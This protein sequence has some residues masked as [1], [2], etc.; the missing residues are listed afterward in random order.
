MSFLLSAS[1]AAYEP[2]YKLLHLLEPVARGCPA[3]AG[4]A[5]PS[6]NVASHV[7]A[8]YCETR[9]PKQ[10]ACVA[11]SFGV[12]GVWDFDKAMVE[13][14]CRVRSFDP[15]CCGGAHPIGPNHDFAP[16][17]LAPYD[18]LLALTNYS[19]A[20]LTL[21]SVLAGY[22]DTK[23]DLLRLS[24]SSRS[25][26]KG[27]RAL[28]DA[29]AQLKWVPQLLLNLHFSESTRYDDYAEILGGLKAAGF[30]PFYVARQP[31]AEYLQIQEGSRELWSRYEAA[32]G[33]TRLR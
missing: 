15:V 13:R 17:A 25:D 2:Q 30:Q 26:W 31:R 6:S 4:T 3:S 20:G 16:L 11:Y 14:G 9:L 5:V 22:G 23:L 28:V 7:E 24:V 32:F 19:T 21:K 10:R 27:L 33:N 18:G 29:P 8:K 12:G 1:L